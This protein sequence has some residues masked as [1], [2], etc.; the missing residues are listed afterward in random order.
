MHNYSIT[1]TN[2][3]ITAISVLAI[4]AAYLAF[5]L[6]PFISKI[7]ISIQPLSPFAVFGVFFFIFDRWAW[8]FFSLNKLLGIPNFNGTWKGDCQSK[9]KKANG[10]K[11]DCTIKIRQTFTQ[12]IVDGSFDTSDSVSFTA[13]VDHV[14]PYRQK[15]VY[16]YLNKP[17]GN[18]VPTQDKHI[19]TVDLDLKNQSELG[20][21]YFTDRHPQSKGTFNLKKVKS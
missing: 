21:S 8:K 15:L 20:G 5:L 10:K 19:G 17:K 9:S 16:S 18:A 12:L 1:N 11:I 14:N 13:S 2:I 6:N 4:G 7:P 3:R